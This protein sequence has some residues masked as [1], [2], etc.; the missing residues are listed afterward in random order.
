LDARYEKPPD[1]APEFD[2]IQTDLRD[3]SLVDQ[4]RSKEVSTVCHLQFLSEVPRNESTFQLNVIG[5]IRL[6]RACAEAGIEKVIL[7]S[8]TAVYGAHPDNSAFLNEQQPLRGGRSYGYL[9]DWLEI[10]TFCDEFSR[11]VPQPSLTRLRFSSIVG[12]T[13]DTPMTRFLK[14]PQAPVLLGFDPMMQVIH[15]QDVVEA[16]ARAVLDDAVGAFNVAARQSLPLS[17]LTGLTDKP[18]LPILHLLAYRMP[19]ALRPA[20][21]PIPPDYLRYPWVGDL[22]RMVETL[23]FQPRHG[24]P[25]ALQSLAALQRVKRYAPQTET[26]RAATGAHSTN[27]PRPESEE[28]KLHG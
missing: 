23:R 9:R 27:R 7:K 16:I 26:S 2:L 20:L 1:L 14:R 3:P 24:A 17:R 18:P 25:E 15:E 8:S 19:R 13:A 5:T 6:L 21:F 28:T 12:P 4:L 10:E 11:R 22:T